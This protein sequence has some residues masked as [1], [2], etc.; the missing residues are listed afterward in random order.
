MGK[1]KASKSAAQSA[2]NQNIFQPVIAALSP[3]E[4]QRRKLGR[5]P[6]SGANT[7]VLGNYS[8]LSGT[9]GG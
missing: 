8:P 2:T 5:A 6:G 3:Q 4:T 9:L 1:K 7:T